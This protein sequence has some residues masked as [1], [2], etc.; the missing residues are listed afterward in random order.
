M[1]IQNLCIYLNH[2]LLQQGIH[3]D[4]F[5]IILQCNIWSMDKSQWL[6]HHTWESSFRIN[7]FNFPLLATAGWEVSR[8]ED[9]GLSSSYMTPMEMQ[10]LRGL[11]GGR[12]P[13]AGRPRLYDRSIAKKYIY[14]YKH[15]HLNEDVWAEWKRQKKTLGFNSDGKFAAYLLSLVSDAPGYVFI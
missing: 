4:I 2:R 9:Q 5:T 12:R 10:D 14:K 11:R 8:G 3:L 6:E 7:L 1:D 13:G 15:I